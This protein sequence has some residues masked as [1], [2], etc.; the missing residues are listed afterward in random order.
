MTRESCLAAVVVSDGA[1]LFEAS[2]PISVFGVDR[3]ASGA[4]ALRVVV[5]SDTTGPLA[6]TAGLSLSG[7]SDL[8]ALEDAGVVIIPTWPD[9]QQPP[10]TELVEALRNAEATGATVM[11]LC[12][13]AY[14]LGYAG[15]LDGRRAITHWRLL[16]DFA[17]R[18]PRT[19]VDESGLYVDEGSIITSAGTAAGLDACLHYVRREFGADAAAAIARRMVVAPHRSGNQNQF[20]QTEPSRPSGTSI[21]GIQERALSNLVQPLSVGLLASWYGTSRRTFDRDFTAAAGTSA[22]QWVIHQRV[23]TA[24]RLLETTDLSVEMVA[25]RSGFTS[26]TALRPNFR[27]ILGLGP[28]Q[29]R[30]AFRTT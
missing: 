1:L 30:D 5:A 23:Y 22:A 4:P 24:Q 21:A 27:R 12:L 16:A 10:S 7:H 9:P 28:Q 18:F 13:G 17:R 3:T 19:R 6:T 20:V 25:H 15:L 29:Y 26:A 14:A 11:G 2:V 8:S